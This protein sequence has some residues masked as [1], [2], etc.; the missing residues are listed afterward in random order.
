MLLQRRPT[1]RSRE[2][3]TSACT[4][5]KGLDGLPTCRSRKW[6]LKVRHPLVQ[7][8]SV[9][10][11]YRHLSQTSRKNDVFDTN[12]AKRAGMQRKIIDPTCLLTSCRSAYWRGTV[13]CASP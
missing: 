5:S 4:F 7:I 12:F 9:V 10:T 8:Y 13:S 3:H 1:S 11:M 2:Q 6:H